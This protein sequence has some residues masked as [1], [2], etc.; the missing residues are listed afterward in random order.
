MVFFLINLERGSRDPLSWLWVLFFNFFPI[1]RKRES[2]DPL[3]RFCVQFFFKKSDLEIFYFFYFCV[4]ESRERI[5]SKSSLE[6]L[7]IFFNESREVSTKTS[8]EQPI[9][10]LEIITLFLGCILKESRVQSGS[11]SSQEALEN[12]DNGIISAWF[13]MFLHGF[14]YPNVYVYLCF[15]VAGEHG[16][17]IFK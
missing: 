14:L 1:S 7:D 10:R 9:S 16:I 8:R 17:P 13:C 4:K 6:I 3:S 15:V 12:L 2:R 11:R 5:I